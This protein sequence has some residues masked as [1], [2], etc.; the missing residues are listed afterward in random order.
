MLTVG[1]EGIDNID[2][3]TGTNFFATNSLDDIDFATVHLWP[4][5]RSQS[6][7]QSIAWLNS[8]INLA[9]LEIN[10]PLVVEEAGYSRSPSQNTDYRDDLFRKIFN[11]IFDKKAG[12]AIIWALYHDSYPDYDGYGVYY[13]RDTATVNILSYQAGRNPFRVLKVP[14][15]YNKIQS[16]IDAASPGDIILISPGVYY[17]NL[18]ISN[19]TQGVALQGINRN[20]CIIDGKRQGRAIDF[21]PS[22]LPCRISGL[23]IRNGSLASWGEMGAGIRIVTGTDVEISNCIIAHNEI[24]YNGDTGSGGGIYCASSSGR[25]L[26][27]IKNNLISDNS[28]A[29]SGGGILLS[30]CIGPAKILNNVI[31]NNTAHI[32]GGGISMTS[33]EVV[34]NVIEGNQAHEYGG[35]GIYCG[36]QG[37]GIYLIGHAL[38]ANNIIKNNVKFKGGSFGNDYR[39][40]GGILN[41]GLFEENY[42]V[43]I[44]NNVFYGNK[45]YHGFYNGRGGAVAIFKLADDQDP[46]GLT[47]LK[48]NIFYGNDAQ[49]QGDEIFCES[50]ARLRITYSLVDPHKVYGADLGKG[51]ISGNPRFQDTL[52][53]HLRSDS[54]AIDAGDPKILDLDSSRSDMGVYGG[55]DSL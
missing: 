14:Q 32:Y 27:E 54:P 36:W 12:G 42:K 11:K 39:A 24:T 37:V 26:I 33:G 1:L 30:P 40:G 25:P 29:Y 49:T 41:A 20:T 35:A 15:Q 34:G 51:C 19:I 22:A 38:I 13:P 17:E 8:R 21:S 7:D 5:K 6:I 48:N 31:T 47:D 16:A 18:R 53:F 10:K 9:Q 44:I 3:T 23:T 43:T 50:G 46:E 45:A 55:P 4:E 2:S 52:T 28:V